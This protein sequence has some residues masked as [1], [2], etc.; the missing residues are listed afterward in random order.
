MK[1]I[2]ALLIALCF[3]GQ[4]LAQPPAGGPPG[5]GPGG[6]GGANSGHLY[7]KLVDSSGKGIGRASVFILKVSAS[8]DGK[9]KEMLVKG[10]TTQNNGDFSAED[11]PINTPLK[12][13]A[14]A[15]GF[16]ELDQEITLKPPTTAKDL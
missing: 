8:Q 12:V 10:L 15:V 3:I 9:Q 14:T 5:G 11:L 7:G 16:A 13:K 1:N 4:T 6:P 2:Y